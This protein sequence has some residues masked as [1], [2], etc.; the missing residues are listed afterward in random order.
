MPMNQQESRISQT[1]RDAGCCEAVINEFLQ[2]QAAGQNEAARKLLLHHRSLL[3][4]QM[5]Q[6]QKPLD[7]LDYFIEETK[8]GKKD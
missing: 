7:I 1:L 6:Q 5:H 2:L 3:L 8:K 4:Y